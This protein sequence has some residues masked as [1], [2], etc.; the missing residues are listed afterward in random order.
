MAG[1]LLNGRVNPTLSICEGHRSDMSLSAVD[2]MSDCITMTDCYHLTEWEC[3]FSAVGA[4]KLNL[5][6]DII[7]MI[8]SSGFLRFQPVNSMLRTLTDS[9]LIS[10]CLR[11]L[12][13]NLFHRMSNYDI[14]V[15]NTTRV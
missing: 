12:N 1:S 6:S 11:V 2:T 13:E 15:V 14:L 9:I 8:V 4:N 7:K 5:L 10:S 3:S